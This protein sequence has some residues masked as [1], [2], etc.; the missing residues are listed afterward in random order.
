MRET[1][2][3]VAKIDGKKTHKLLT[4]QLLILQAVSALDR[5]SEISAKMWFHMLFLTASTMYN[6]CTV[7]LVLM[8]Y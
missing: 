1:V 7:Q 2:N 6:S 5:N 4:F 8:I 3:F